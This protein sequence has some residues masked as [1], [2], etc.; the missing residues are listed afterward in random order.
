MCTR[1]VSSRGVLLP[2]CVLHLDSKPVGLTRVLDGH[3]LLVEVV[4]VHA[5]RVVYRWVGMVWCGVCTGSWLALG[6]VCCSLMMCVALV[7]A[8][9]WG[10]P[11]GQESLSVARQHTLYQGGDVLDLALPWV[12]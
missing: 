2:R 5:H 9:G 3:Y 8:V 1:S 7:P 10:T 12:T 4:C 11:C 6:V